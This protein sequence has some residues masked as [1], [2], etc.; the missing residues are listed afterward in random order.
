MDMARSNNE[1]NAEKGG[2]EDSVKK[3]PQLNG[4]AVH[5]QVGDQTAAV[6]K[7]TGVDRAQS[8]VGTVTGTASGGLSGATGLA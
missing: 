6:T 4:N 2:K 5:K 1:K 7:A 8:S 3:E